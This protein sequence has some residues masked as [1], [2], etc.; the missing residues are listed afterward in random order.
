MH[1]RSCSR[2]QSWAMWCV[3]CAHAHT[4]HHHHRLMTTRLGSSAVHPHVTHV[5]VT[6]VSH[7]CVG[8]GDM[9]VAHTQCTPRIHTV[10]MSHIPRPTNTRIQGA[11]IHSAEDGLQLG[12]GTCAPTRSTLRVKPRTMFVETTKCVREATT[13]MVREAT[14]CVRAATNRETCVG[15]HKTVFVKPPRTVFVGRL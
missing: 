6:H 13:N 2:T 1:H 12:S 8:V 14:N 10:C 4:P 5:H 15:N 3:S 11:T 7:M 9:V